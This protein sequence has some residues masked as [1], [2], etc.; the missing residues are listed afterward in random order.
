MNIINWLLC[1]VYGHRR[2]RKMIEPLGM[3][4]Y[5]RCPR[6]GATWTRKAKAQANPNVPASIRR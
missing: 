4:I 6:C 5:Y 2:G 1:K 3:S